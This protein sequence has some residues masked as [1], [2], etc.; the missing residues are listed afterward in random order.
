MAYTR[1]GITYAGCEP[2]P[3]WVLSADERA[4]LLQDHNLPD[5]HTL[6]PLWALR[7]YPEWDPRLTGCG[8]IAERNPNPYAPANAS[9][10][11]RID[12]DWGDSLTAYADAART[13]LDP[14]NRTKYETANPEPMAL[15]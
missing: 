8:P 5:P 15:F 10:H 13:V 14:A 11:A 7:T 4:D 3:P 9:E 6:G 1:D 12:F 2:A